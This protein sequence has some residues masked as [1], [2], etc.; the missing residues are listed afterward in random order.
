MAEE[1]KHHMVCIP[2]PSQS[3]IKAM[4][5]LAKLLHHRG[6]YITFVN[7]EYNQKRLCRAGQSPA[8]ESL[9]ND[10][11]FE[12]IKDGLP[13]FDSTA[14]PDFISLWRSLKDNGTT[15]VWNLLAT[16]SDGA[17]LSHNP[18]VT[19]IISDG[20]MPFT[21]EVAQRAR[22]PI[23]LFWTIAACAFMGCYQFQAL[24]EKGLAPLNDASYLTNGYLEKTIDWIPGMKEIRLRDLPSLI[25]TV[26]PNDILFNAVM[27]SAQTAAKASANIIHTFDALEADV[28]HVL[29]SM[30]PRVHAI[31]P[32]QLHLNQISNLDEKLKSLGYSLW[33]EESECLGWLDSKE[34]QS[35]VYVN[36]GSI[37]VMTEQ[38]F[39]EFAWGLANSRHYFLWIIRPDLIMG[40]SAILPPEFSAEIKDKGLTVSW[41]PQEEVLNHPSIGGFLTHG[42]WNSIV[43]SICAGVPMLCWPFGADQT[44]NCRYLCREWEIGMEID[45]DV[46]REE[47]EKLVR[48]LMGGEQMKKRAMEWKKLAE[49]A[50]S[51][52]GSSS[53]SLENLINKVL[54]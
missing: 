4:L 3:H 20:F 1:N 26:D 53:L 25:R 40:E 10:F 16:L 11:K 17:T 36:F 34:A 46:K 18:P 5:K 35:V 39:I 32:I 30:F 54:L 21:M 15:L 19:A 43:E 50:T 12:I 52:D 9:P 41:C 22:V 13:P 37:T 6:F 2:F 23:I 47:V 48:E 45:K 27:E 31:G 14:G 44:T 51:L 7:T 24:K 42:G 33:R 8:L 49:E 29:R 28:L 38:Q